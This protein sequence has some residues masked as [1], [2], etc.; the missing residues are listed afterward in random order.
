MTLTLTLSLSLSLTLTLTLTRCMS[1]MAK[2]AARFL[3]DFGFSIGIG[4]V[5]PTPN[6]TRLK[7]ALIRDGTARCRERIDEF[8]RGTLDPMP[9]CTAEQ[10][11]T[12]RA[13][14]G[15]WG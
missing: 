8:E 15:V 12:A 7:A 6:L 1:R 5:M 10:A 2:L 14:G 11:S 9:G 4:D 13:R 3:C